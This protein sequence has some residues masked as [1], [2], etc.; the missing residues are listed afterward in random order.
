MAII[1]SEDGRNAQ[2][3]D[4]SRISKEGYLQEYIL[5]NPESIPVYELKEDKKLFV[6][7]REFSTNSGPIDALAIDQYGDIYIVETKLYKNPDKRTVVAQALDY[8]AALWK[9]FNDFSEFIA[10]LN[11]E[12]QK[13]FNMTFQEKV[14]EFFEL[15]ADQL[16]AMI[17]AF[18]K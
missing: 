2:K 3:I 10:I 15:D 4:K 6:A 17:K 14:A 16:S 12:S 5:N 13:I 9:H 1:I 11:N 7:K 18:G 8:G